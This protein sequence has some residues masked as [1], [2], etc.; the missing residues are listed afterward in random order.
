MRA[1]T[2]YLVIVCVTTLVVI[3]LMSYAGFSNGVMSLKGF[4]GIFAALF[5]THEVQKRN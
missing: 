5:G 2:A 4:I 1:A 3:G